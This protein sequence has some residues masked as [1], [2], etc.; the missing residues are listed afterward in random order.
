MRLYKQLQIWSERRN[1]S[2]TNL[3]GSFIFQKVLP[4]HQVYYYIM[5]LLYHANL[6]KCDFCNSTIGYFVVFAACLLYQAIYP[7]LCMSIFAIKHNINFL[8]YII[9]IKLNMIQTFLVIIL[10]AVYWDII[11]LKR[12][13]QYKSADAQTCGNSQHHGFIV[14]IMV[15]HIV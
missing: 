1:T 13:Q 8:Q 5:G 11:Y 12:I 3:F 15:L 7:S 2:L 4:I 6:N 14:L 10:T 9:T